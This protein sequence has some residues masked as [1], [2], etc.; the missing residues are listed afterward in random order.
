MVVWKTSS[1]APPSLLISASTFFPRL[2]ISSLPEAANLPFDTSLWAAESVDQGVLRSVGQFAADR[3][4]TVIEMLGT[5][6]APCVARR[7]EN[8]DH[9]AP[10]CYKTH[11]EYHNI[12]TAR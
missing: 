12:N 5:T 6:G 7:T 8:S 9:R 11:R 4:S 3:W 10:P 1:S 2:R